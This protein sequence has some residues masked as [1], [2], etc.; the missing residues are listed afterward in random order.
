MPFFRRVENSKM[1][2]W[3][4]KH[5]FLHHKIMFCSWIILI[6]HLNKYWKNIYHI[7]KPYLNTTRIDHHY[8]IALTNHRW[9]INVGL[10]IWKWI[11]NAK[12][13]KDKIDHTIM[14]HLQLDSIN[15]KH[16]F[17]VPLKLCTFDAYLLTC[18]ESLA[19]LFHNKS[20]AVGYQ[21]FWAS[22]FTIEEE[23]SYIYKI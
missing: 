16:N 18:F 5:C 7:Y 6:A 23:K 17:H 3:K 4:H 11:T 1:V 20:M 10:W 13:K 8:T 22:F 12:L 2:G 21:L 9:N 14:W 15:H 19:T